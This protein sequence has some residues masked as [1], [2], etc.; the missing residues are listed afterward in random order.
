VDFKVLNTDALRIER[1]KRRFILKN[2]GV[3]PAQS[4]PADTTHKPAPADI[5]PKPAPAETPAKPAPA[6][7]PKP[8]PA[9]TTKKP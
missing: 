7:A 8:A 4:A 1:E 2:E 5:T 3:P 6:P 9:D